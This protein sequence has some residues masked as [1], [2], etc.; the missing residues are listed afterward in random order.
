M[1]SFE[2]IILLGLLVNLVAEVILQTIDYFIQKKDKFN[3][4]LKKNKK[5]N[6][7]L[8]VNHPNTPFTFNGNQ[9][10]AHI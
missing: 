7:E 1:Q 10:V 3:L 8:S 4:S 6:I 5:S 2:E 9:F